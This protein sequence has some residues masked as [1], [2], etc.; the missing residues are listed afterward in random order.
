MKR[1]CEDKDLQSHA[2]DV[3]EDQ[4][5]NLTFFQLKG[6][7]SNIRVYYIEAL[8]GYIKTERTRFYAIIT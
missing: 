5:D 8:I 1:I 3:L 4:E 7:Q 2:E 6:V